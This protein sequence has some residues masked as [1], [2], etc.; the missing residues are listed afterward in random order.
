MTLVVI[1]IALLHA[2]PVLVI[3]VWTRSRTALVIAAV[4]L[5]AVGVLIGNP[6]YMVVDLVGVAIGFWSGM[7]ALK[8]LKPK[9]RPIIPAQPVATTPQPASASWIGAVV[10]VGLVAGIV[11]NSTADK[12]ARPTPHAVASQPPV[13]TPPQ[14]TVSPLQP[15]PELTQRNRPISATTNQ[16]VRRCLDMANAE[17]ISRCADQAK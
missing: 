11:Y 15:R 5:G 3:G 2:V 7:F 1:F 13:T 10:V 17:A 9:A 12:D 4:M 8:F 14:P 6:A 16:D